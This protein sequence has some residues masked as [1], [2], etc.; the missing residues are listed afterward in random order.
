TEYRSRVATGLTQLADLFSAVRGTVLSET[1]KKLGDALAKES[2]PGIESLLSAA[3]VRLSSE[4]SQWKQYR[5][6]TQ[7]CQAMEYLATRRPAL[8]KELRSRTEI[9]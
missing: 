8:E 4:A 6:V 7:A 1:M 5:A 3:F 9:E 2:D